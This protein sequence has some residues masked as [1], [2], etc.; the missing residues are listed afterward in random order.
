MISDRRALVDN[1]AARIGALIA[2]GL[3][4]ILIARTGGPSAVGT[5][6]LLRVLPGLV[7]VAVSCGLPGATPFFLASRRDDPS[8]RPTII[9]AT[10]VAAAVSALFW[11]ALT[12]LLR[13]VFFRSL[14]MSLVALIGVAV[15]TQLFV[16]VGKSCLQGSDDMRGAAWAIAAEEAAFL[17]AYA[18]LL[19]FVHGVALML[20]A[21]V[22]ADVV[23]TL[24]IACR[25]L[26]WG[27]DSPPWGH[28][29]RHLAYEIAHYGMRGQLGGIMELLNLRLD[30]AI[31]GALAGPA[32]LGTYAIASKYAELLRLPGLAITYVLYPRFARLASAAARERVAHWLPRLA[33]L[34]VLAA[35][36][37]FVTVKPLLP[38]IYGASFKGAITPTYVLLIGLSAGTVSGLLSAY[39]YGEGRPGLNSSALGFGLLVTAVLDAVLIPRFGALGAA[40]A[41]TAAY[42]ATSATLLAC[43]WWLGRA[44]SRAAGSELVS[45]R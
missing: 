16:A 1:V 6:A 3:A 44:A 7:G 24:G 2:L 39:L 28:P 40:W 25:L 19:P 21:L 42:L 26:Y 27:F 12:P 32:V 31:L 11:I 20:A 36:P 14:S 23:V 4:T 29:S 13:H 41:S 22:V 35:I 10:D 9:R 18:V 37:L 43:F 34:G 30:F 5:Y 15:F 38:L 33:L 17:P 45:V 8:L